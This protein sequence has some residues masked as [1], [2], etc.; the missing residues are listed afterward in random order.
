M[1]YKSKAFNLQVSQ[2]IEK[3]ELRAGKARPTAAAGKPKPAAAAVLIHT[4]VFMSLYI[5]VFI[6]VLLTPLGAAGKDSVSN[7]SKIIVYITPFI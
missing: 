7:T 3:C 1:C 6:D 4:Y 2:S 5:N